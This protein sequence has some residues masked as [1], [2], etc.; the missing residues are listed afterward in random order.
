MNDYDSFSKEIEVATNQIN[1]KISSTTERKGG[2]KLRDRLV[3]SR[4]VWQEALSFVAIIQSIVIFV[5]L[6]PQS[7]VTVNSFFAWLGIQY[8]FPI[9]VASSIVVVFII[10]VFIF[11]ILAV[12]YIG[13]VKSANEIGSKMNPSN[14]LMWNQLKELERKVDNLARK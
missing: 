9:T 10:V 6:V 4:V 14:Y 2:L 1:L 12:R 11:G 13:T 3:F 8:E 5:A 7:V